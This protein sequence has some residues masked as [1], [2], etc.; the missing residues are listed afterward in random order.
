MLPMYIVDL[1]TI[2]LSASTLY[3]LTL[4]QN[5]F[6]C[7]SIGEKLSFHVLKTMKVCTRFGYFGID[8]TACTSELFM[9]I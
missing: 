1:K 7:T 4:K 8:S 9:I 2:N 3:W 5:L 6:Y